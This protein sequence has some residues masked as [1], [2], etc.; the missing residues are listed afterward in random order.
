MSPFLFNHLSANLPLRTGNFGPII[1]R[2]FIFFIKHLFLLPKIFLLEPTDTI[3]ACRKWK[4][5]VEPAVLLI[6]HDCFISC[7]RQ[8]F[9]FLLML[10]LVRGCCLQRLTCLRP[11]GELSICGLFTSEERMKLFFKAVPQPFSGKS[12]FISRLIEESSQ[13]LGVASR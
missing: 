3:F 10:F 8:S 12:T 6:Y 13:L 5:S 7:S 2:A 11:W 4:P 9:Y 1:T